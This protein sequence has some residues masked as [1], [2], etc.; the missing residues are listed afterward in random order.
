MRSTSRAGIVTLRNLVIE[1]C[2]AA[3][4]GGVHLEVGDGAVGDVTLDR[5]QFIDNLAQ[6]A[7]LP[8]GGGMQVYIVESGHLSVRDSLFSGNRAESANPGAF[9]LGGGLHL[10]ASPGPIS[11]EISGTTFQ[12][13]LAGAPAGGT[14]GG[15]LLVASAGTS[16][17]DRGLDLRGERR[18]GLGIDRPGAGAR[19][20]EFRNRRHRAT[21]AASDR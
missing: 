16:D 13:N 8:S 20:L 1:S 15:V 11:V 21:T 3:S 6:E 14:G 12:S 18:G 9:A 17:A 4:G 5:V 10:V 2:R 19:N 7:S